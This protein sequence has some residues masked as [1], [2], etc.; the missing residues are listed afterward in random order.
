MAGTTTYLLLLTMN[1]KD[2]NSSFKRHRMAGRI[3][4]QDL[5]MLYKKHTSLERQ[6]QT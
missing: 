2:L 1:I 5:T 6:T 3:K 4:K